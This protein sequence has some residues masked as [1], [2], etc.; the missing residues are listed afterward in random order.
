MRV[1]RGTRLIGA[2][3]IAAVALAVSASLAAAAPQSY[4]CS[5]TFDSPGVLAGEHGSV[6]VEG[7]CFVNQ[8]PAT[9]HGNVTLAPGSALISAFASGGS[10]LSVTG[11][12]VVQSGATL[13]LGCEPGAFTCLDDPSQEHPTLFSRGAVTGDLIANEP[14]GVIV[15]ASTIGGSVNERGGGGG[16]TCD[17][18][19]GFAKF[20]SPVYSDYEDTAI[21]GNLSVRSLTSCWLGVARVHVQGNAS[22][23]HV[24]L[25][26]PDGIEIIDNHVGRNLACYDNSMVW[27]SADLSPTGALWPR[28]PEPNTVGGTRLGQ[29]VLA[30][31]ATDN[32]PPGPGPF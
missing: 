4:T 5:G 12:V 14:L 16:F 23:V 1:S 3:G 13:L 9:V 10:S 7:W 26:D 15:H 8:G 6:L 24:N 21:G 20:G 27:D 18:L 11:N 31:P 29:C 2:A 32:G 22:F 19:G 28:Q 25:L 30:S 17:P